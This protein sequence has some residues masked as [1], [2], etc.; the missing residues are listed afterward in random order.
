[1][2]S[3]S[4]FTLSPHSSLRIAMDVPFLHKHYLICDEYEKTEA[5]C[6]ECNRQIGGLAVTCESCN[7]WLHQSC[8]EQKLPPQISHPVHSKLHLQEV[9]FDSYQDFIC[10]KCFNLC[11]G[12]SYCDEEFSLVLDVRCSLSTDDDHDQNLR[13]EDSER[14][15][16]LGRSN[17]QH[18]CHEH[19]LTLFNYRK[20]REFQYCCN[21]CDKPLSGMSFGCVYGCSDSPFFLHE[22][23][24]YAMPNKILEHPFHMSH[25]LYIN[26]LSFARNISTLTRRP[27][28]SKQ[29]I[30]CAVCTWDITDKEYCYS[31][32]KCSFHVHVLCTKFKPTLRHE[33]HDHCLTYTETISPRGGDLFS[34]HERF[35]CRKC[36]TFS[37]TLPKEIY[38]CM[39]CKW[40]FHFECL[41]QST[42]THKYHMHPLSAMTSFKEDDCG[43]YY[44]DIC[45]EE[46]SPN[47]PVYYC[48]ECEYIAHIECAL[49]K[50]IKHSSSLHSFY[51]ITFRFLVSIS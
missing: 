3:L 26:T 46:R 27:I 42:I 38:R 2:C 16:E 30:A 45:E 44:C 19:S 32:H 36:N 17:I 1:M 33:C 28:L 48:K 4:S 40:S 13:G 20:V 41:I 10:D 47:H 34:G 9:L 11:R 6:D 12:N 14:S 15:K 22:S 23:R 31:C 50:V 24:L 25:P 37:N 18:F 8:A 21:W 29:F 35:H 51:H 5:L 39:Q 43:E 7:F 49:G